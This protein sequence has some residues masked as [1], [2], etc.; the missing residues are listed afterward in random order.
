MYF[1]TSSAAGSVYIN[2]LGI[3]LLLAS[4]LWTKVENMIFVSR[5]HTINLG[6]PVQKNAQEFERRPKP[7]KKRINFASVFTV[8]VKRDVI[9]P[10]SWF[11]QYLVQTICIYI[12][13]YFRSVAVS[14]DETVRAFFR[15]LLTN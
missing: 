11:Y 10:G 13:F 2:I 9:I 15:P 3:F 8:K 12:F 14:I 4:G 5:T 7:T 1:Q 6:T